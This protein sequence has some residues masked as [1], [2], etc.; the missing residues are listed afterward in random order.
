[1]K[2]CACNFGFRRSGFSIVLATE[3]PI[4]LYERIQ[5]HDVTPNVP[6]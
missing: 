5:P 2:N 1:M 6:K 4:G 3:C